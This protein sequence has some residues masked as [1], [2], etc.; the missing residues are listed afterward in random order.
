MWT[1]DELRHFG[2]CE[3]EVRR[4][5]KKITA[6]SCSP[7]KLYLVSPGHGKLASQWDDCAF[8]SARITLLWRRQTAEDGAFNLSTFGT[9]KS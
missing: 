6:I 5:R 2:G 7:V 4:S 9:K 3:S 1:V 8:T